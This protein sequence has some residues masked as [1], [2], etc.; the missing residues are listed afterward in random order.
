ML[1]GICL[2]K[3]PVLGAGWAGGGEAE[4]GIFG[5]LRLSEFSL[6]NYGD[7]NWAPSVGAG[8]MIAN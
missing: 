4:Q 7:G 3:S 6:G 1:F 2:A 8:K 5:A